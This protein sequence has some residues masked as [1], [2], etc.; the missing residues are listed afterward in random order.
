MAG[1]SRLQYSPDIKIVRL[2]CTGRVDLTFILRALMNGND[3]VFIG[4]CW[5]GECHYITEGNY[6]AMSM[7]HLGKKL[8]EHVGLNPDRFRMEQ[9][10]AS[11]GIRFSEVMNDFAKTLKSL[12]PLGEAEGLDE[13]E[14]RTRLEEVT[15]LV[16]YIKLAKSDKLALRLEK[17]EEYDALFTR[18]EIDELLGDVPAYYIDPEKCRACMMCRNRCPVKAIDG[19]RSRIH[20]IDQEACIKCGTC[21]EVCPPRFGAVTKLHEVPVPPPIPEEDR[22]IT[23]KGKTEVAEIAIAVD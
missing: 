22:T 20:I 5:L 14:L 2:M 13:D 19:D 6:D 12:G 16:P 23:R 10:S 21:L 17:A 15:R 7:M 18:E 9:I 8:I 11:E 3:G 4:G 1:V